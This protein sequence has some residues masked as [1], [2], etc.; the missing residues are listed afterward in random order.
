MK[1]RDERVQDLFF[2]VPEVAGQPTEEGQTRLYSGDVFGFVDGLLCTLTGWLLTSG[3]LQPKVD[4]N[5]IRLYD[6]AGTAWGTIDRSIGNLAISV[7]GTGANAL[8]KNCQKELTQ[9]GGS[10]TSQYAQVQNGGDA[11]CHTIYGDRTTKLYGR[12]RHQNANVTSEYM[13]VGRDATNGYIRVYGGGEIL[14][15]TQK[16]LEARLSGSS[17][18]EMLKVLSDLGDA[19]KV[20]ADL[21]ARFYGDVTHEG[22]VLPDVNASRNIGSSSLGWD[23][24]F[25]ADYVRI[26]GGINYTELT[27]GRINCQNTNLTLNG[28]FGMM[29]RILQIFGDSIFKFVGNASTRKGRVRV[30]YGT[31]SGSTWIDTTHDGTDGA[32][33][34]GSGDLRLKAPAGQRIVAEKPL[35]LPSYTVATTPSASPAGQMI[36]VSDET[37]GAVPAFS[38]GRD[39]RRV[40]D[41]VIVS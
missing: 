1:T 38:D 33:E 16:V 24:G 17:S 13:D 40:T 39:W 37:G 8:Y 23:R 30:F 6:S 19:F 27:G 11:A 41:R 9:L 35:Q 14:Q 29:F 31:G 2:E 5:S 32:L 22:H 21:T 20:F 7:G 36:Y 26:N 34:S 3:Y 28:G 12:Q 18:S 25:F 15:L 4:G 10:T